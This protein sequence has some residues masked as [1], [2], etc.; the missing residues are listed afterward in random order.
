MAEDRITQARWIAVMAITALCVYLC[1]LMLEPFLYALMWAAVLKIFFEPVHRWLLA[2]T[3][4]ALC[5]HNLL[6]S[7]DGSP[8]C[9]V[10][11]LRVTRGLGTASD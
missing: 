3:R 7:K 4:R 1:W 5:S 2:K 11:Q 10:T 8:Y 6:S 9:E